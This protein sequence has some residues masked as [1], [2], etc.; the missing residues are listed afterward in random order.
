MARKLKAAGFKQVR[1]LAGGI[2]AWRS[3]GFPVEQGAAP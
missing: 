3:Q 2:S 1:P